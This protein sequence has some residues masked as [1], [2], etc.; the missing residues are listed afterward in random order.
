M[1]N[2]WSFFGN[3]KPWVPLANP[4]GVAPGLEAK[5]MSG[6]MFRR[7]VT[8]LPFDLQGEL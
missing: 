6:L 3:E 5:A 8:R 2:L 4:C 1:I 7:T